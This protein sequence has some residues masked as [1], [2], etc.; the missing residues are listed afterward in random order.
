LAARIGPHAGRHDAANPPD[1]GHEV[2]A[3]R[4]SLGVSW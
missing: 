4:H 2:S 1:R 3:S